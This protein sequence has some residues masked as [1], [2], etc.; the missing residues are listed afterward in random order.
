[1]ASPGS[2]GVLSKRSG[3]LSAAALVFVLISF[4]RLL[5]FVR[6]LVIARYFGATAETDAFLLAWMVPETVSP[7]LLEGALAFVLIPLFARELEKEGT[8]KTL[9]SLTFPPVAVALLVLSAAVALSAPWTVPLL[10]PGLSASTELAAVRMVG[11]ASVTIFFIGLAGYARA[12]LNSQNIFGVP[13]AVYAMYNIGILGSI[14]LL[15]ERL[16]I[17]SAALGLALG[18][19]LMLLVQVPTFVR[20]VGLPR[21]LYFKLDRGLLYEFAAFV[22]VGVFV[23]GRHAQVYVERYLGSFLEPGAISQLNYAVRVGQFPMFAGISIA[24]VSFPAVVRAAAARRTGEVERAVESDL[25]MVSALMLPAAAY[26]IL[27]APEVIS[28]LLERGAFTA[29]DTAATASILRVYSTGLLAHALIYV[30]VRPFFTYRDSLWTP[31]RAA[32]AGL[33]VTVAVD[34]ALLESLGA[35]GLAAGNA[36]G[37]SVMALLLIR[38]MKRH[39]VNVDTR[40]LAGFFVRALGAVLLAGSCTLPLVLFDTFADLPALAVL[41][42]GGVVLGPAYFLLGRL[43]GIGE[44]EELLI[45]AQRML[46]RRGRE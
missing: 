9:L 7:L 14:L 13:A 32:L 28:V 18:S 12:A 26:L 10:A 45:Q 27:F 22:P 42:L 23:L 41:I 4:G 24:F 8:L 29:E 37:I 31:I 44:L 5:G 40:R 35:D 30:T 39:V 11:I 1:M 2:R 20:E 15:H 19:A 43:F 36:A 21:R 33:A 6:D 16:G 3:L 38:D 34:V 25:K 17:Y 46:G